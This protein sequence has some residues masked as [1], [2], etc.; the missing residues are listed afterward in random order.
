MAICAGIADSYQGVFE[1]FEKIQSFASQKSNRDDEF[2]TLGV[3]DV[4]KLGDIVGDEQYLSNEL[5]GQ[6]V[7]FKELKT[8]S[9][10]EKQ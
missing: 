9:C 2:T 4:Q 6:A 8:W 10:R 5:E 3:L 1:V 7:F